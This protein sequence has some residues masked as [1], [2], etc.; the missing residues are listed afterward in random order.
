MSMTNYQ[1]KQKKNPPIW[2]GLKNLTIKNYL[3]SSNST[4]VSFDSV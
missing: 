1:K 4:S 2:V 3:T